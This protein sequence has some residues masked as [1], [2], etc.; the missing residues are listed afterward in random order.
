MFDHFRYYGTDGP[1]FR[2]LAPVLAER[3]YANNIRS[4][5]DG[6]S[7]V[8]LVEAIGVVQLAASGPSSPGLG[9]IK[10]TALAVSE[11]GTRELNH[12]C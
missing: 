11:C 7:D 4:I 1:D 9:A 2:K 8:E 10:R 6:L 3:M 5:L 12:G